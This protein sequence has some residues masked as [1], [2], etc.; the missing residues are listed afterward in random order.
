MFPDPSSKSARNFE[1]AKDVL[2]GGNSR[3]TIDLK[4]YPIYVAEASGI[5]RRDPC[6]EALPRAVKRRGSVL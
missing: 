4:P 6:Q 1:R 2:P 5:F 3:S